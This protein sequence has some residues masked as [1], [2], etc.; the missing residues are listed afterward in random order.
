MK[1]EQ[2]EAFNAAIATILDRLENED[3][4]LS[5]YYS[6]D[7]VSRLTPQDRETRIEGLREE[8]FRE[9]CDGELDAKTKVD[10]ANALGVTPEDI[11]YVQTS[12]RT[13]YEYDT[14]ET[15]VKVKDNYFCITGYY[16]SWD[17]TYWNDPRDS[18]TQVWPKH[19]VSTIWSNS[20]PE[21]AD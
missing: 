13:G 21:D 6:D 18:W 20:P 10:L 17:G 14:S 15:V 19:V 8:I 12:R 16:S 11:Q 9:L 1:T 5:D 2:S 7:Y 3:V 4:N